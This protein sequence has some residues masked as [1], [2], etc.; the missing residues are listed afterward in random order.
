MHFIRIPPHVA[1]E[2]SIRCAK[3]GEAMNSN[4]PDSWRRQLRAQISWAL[5]LKA[6]ALT[7]LWLLFFR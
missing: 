3:G 1:N 7:L 5:V 2:R 6:L 4:L